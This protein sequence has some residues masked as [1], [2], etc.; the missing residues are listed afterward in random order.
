M[1]FKENSNQESII[2]SLNKSGLPSEG[3]LL[4][5]E[6]DTPT[7][8]Y[9]EEG[10]VEIQVVVEAAEAEAPN[11]MGSIVSGLGAGTEEGD[12]LSSLFI[13][14]SQPYSWSVRR[15][16][17]DSWTPVFSSG[18]T[19][20]HRFSATAGDRYSFILTP[21]PGVD[22]SQFRAVLSYSF[23]RRPPGFSPGQGGSVTGSVASL[24]SSIVNG[25]RTLSVSVALGVFYTVERLNYKWQYAE[26]GSEVWTD[27]DPE[28]PGFIGAG[29]PTLRLTR[30]YDGQNLGRR[31]RVV[32]TSSYFTM[33]PITSQEIPPASPTTPGRPVILSVTPADSS[34]S[35]TWQAFNGFST[36]TDY[37]VEY[38]EYHGSSPN[39]WMEFAKDPSDATSV[40][41]T[42]LENEKRYAFRVAAVN[43]VGQGPYSAQS[44]S[45]LPGI[46]PDPPVLL[47]ATPGIGLVT[48]DW[49]PAPSYSGNDY[50]IERSSNDGASWTLNTTTANTNA[51][52]RF[53]TGGI[54]NSF[55][56]RARGT[57]F[58]PSE[59]SNVIKATPTSAAPYP[60]V[61]LNVYVY[62]YDG[63]EGLGLNWDEDPRWPG[64]PKT[65]V[66]AQYSL[67]GGATWNSISSNTPNGAHWI[68]INNW[69]SLIPRNTEFLFRAA[70]INAV[71]QGEWS[72]PKAGTTS[73]NMVPSLFAYR[74]QSSATL[75]W[76]APIPEGNAAIIDYAVGIRPGAQVGNDLWSVDSGNR[77]QNNTNSATSI[78]VTRLTET[79]ATVNNLTP[80]KLYFFSIRA[81]NSGRT[82]NSLFVFS[83]SLTGLGK[84]MNYTRPSITPY[85]STP[86]SAPVNA[87]TALTGRPGVVYI[88]TE[89]DDANS[90]SLSWTAPTNN[91]GLEVTGYAMQ[92]SADNGS[93]WSNSNDYLDPDYCLACP[94]SR[95]QRP[96]NP[97]ALT[98]AKVKNLTLMQPHV[99]RVAAI[100]EIG[101]GP[102]S[103]ASDPVTPTKVPLGPEGFVA[104][105]GNGSVSLSWTARTVDSERL[106]VIGY[107]VQYRTSG[108]TTGMAWTPAGPWIIF[109]GNTL[110]TGTSAVVTGLTSGK[111]YDFYVVAVNVG[112]PGGV[113]A[114]LARTPT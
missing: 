56:I 45:V 80:G 79:S 105:A 69:P 99:F 94:N 97:P 4:L 42:G 113:S 107:N 87:P 68:N 95:E 19:W 50:S 39:N 33:N 85:A 82:R 23:F 44:G 58:R 26:Q 70:D 49:E 28:S 18:S 53:L 98:T 91:G 24:S 41:V 36:I 78:T 2:F 27:L 72:E 37:V 81:V 51:T 90:V 109:N 114:M 84:G 74:G 48:L 30:E 101:T 32:V 110:I 111:S 103:V 77:I 88:M 61:N 14:Y 66:A 47:S 71:G 1:E 73:P 83:Q 31:H 63:V 75:N 92:Y 25:I 67:D 16:T 5:Q 106:P 13:S 43:A 34:A 59:P 29:T 112:G 8:D 35:L 15:R 54:E 55:R 96:L 21:T 100:N 76:S 86:P 17:A 60:P 89:N 9:D 12:S 3:S 20:R 40:T 57:F 10:D 62:Y 52:L 104:T 7:V 11:F 108:Y 64:T 46:M 102:Y 6:G 38:T 22:R 93:T 65:G